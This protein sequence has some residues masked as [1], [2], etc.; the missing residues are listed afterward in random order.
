MSCVMI[1]LLSLLFFKD[2]L[3]KYVSVKFQKQRSN[4]D[5]ARASISPKVLGTRSDQG[6][7]K[8]LVTSEPPYLLADFTTRAEQTKSKRC[9]T[10]CDRP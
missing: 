10:H 3:S 5:R 8:Y 1:C 7:T 2:N 9:A 4:Q 6:N